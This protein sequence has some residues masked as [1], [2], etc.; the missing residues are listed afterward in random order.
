MGNDERK[1]RESL[2]KLYETPGGV[3]DGVR[4]WCGVVANKLGKRSELKKFECGVY[5]GDRV[6]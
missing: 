5:V 4:M 6:L 1:L 2:S 3:D